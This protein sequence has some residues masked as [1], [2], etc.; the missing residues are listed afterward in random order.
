MKYFDQRW[1]G[2]A[3]REIARL[4]AEHREKLR[5]FVKASVESSSVAEDVVHDV[6]VEALRRYDVLKEHPN[7][8]GWLYVTA[9]HKVQEYMRKSYHSKTV[10]MDES[11]AEM[12][13]RDKG[14]LETEWNQTIT[15]LL[16][17]DELQRFRRYFLWGYTVEE[18]AIKEGISI[19]NMRVRLNRLKNK[20]L[21]EIRDE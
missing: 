15:D 13:E 7:Q 8:L 6:F 5:I 14:F 4:Y 10:D 20:L 2:E 18:L 21:R 16:T 19:N 1:E 17:P 3:Q 12:G 11:I 9:R